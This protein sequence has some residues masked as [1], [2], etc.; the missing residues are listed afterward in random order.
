MEEQQS[1]ANFSGNSGPQLS[2][3]RWRVSFHESNQ[4]V[5]HVRH[6]TKTPSLCSK[7]LNSQGFTTNFLSNEIADN[8]PVINIRSGSLSIEYPDNPYLYSM[9]PVIIKH[10]SFSHSLSLIIATPD[11]YL[12]DIA[13]VAL[14]LWMHSGLASNFIQEIY[15]QPSPYSHHTCTAC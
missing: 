10:Q 2:R 1:N 11:S 12:I 14:F 8:T 5:N 15:Y 13:P 9:L 7:S 6:I 4:S 3:Q